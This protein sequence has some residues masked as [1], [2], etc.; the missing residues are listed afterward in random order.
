MNN[1]FAS[2]T[3]IFKCLNPAAMRKQPENL[4]SHWIF[5]FFIVFCPIWK[6]QTMRNMFFDKQLEVHT[7]HWMHFGS[8]CSNLGSNHV[9]SLKSVQTSNLPRIESKKLKTKKNIL[10][11]E[12]CF[13]Q[14]RNSW[15][16]FKPALSSLTSQKCENLHRF[17]HFNEKCGITEDVLTSESWSRVLWIYQI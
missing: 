5:Q 2:V 15:S 12:F 17:Q 3:C 14:K 16:N 1:N 4:N 11:K 6:T 9:G 13:A 10:T 7:N 8:W